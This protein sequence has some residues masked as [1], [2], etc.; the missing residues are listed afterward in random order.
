MSIS[1]KQLEANQENAQKPPVRRGGTGPK[2]EAGKTY[3]GWILWGICWWL[4]SI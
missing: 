2:T 3:F 4:L 1:E